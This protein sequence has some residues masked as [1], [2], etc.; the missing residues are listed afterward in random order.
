MEDKEIKILEWYKNGNAEIT[1]YEDG[2]RITDYPDNEP[3]N[4]DYPLSIDLCITNHCTMGCPFCYNNSN[5]NGKHGDIMNLK[6]LDTMPRG[7]EI[8]IGGGSATDHP[9]LMPFLEMLKERGLIANLTVSQWELIN[10]LDLVN[11]MIDKDL[12]HGLGVSYKEP[13]DLIYSNMTGQN[14]VV[15]LI[16]GVHGKEVFD[17]LSKFNVKILI[18]GYKELQRGIYYKDA[19]DGEVEKKIEWLKENLKDYLDKFDVISF[20]NLALKQ[21]DV[22][23]M[24]SEKEW[25]EFYQGNDGQVSCYVDAVNQKVSVSSL[26]VSKSIA[27]EDDMKEMFKK[28]KEIK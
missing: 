17:Y 1:I 6:F 5:A 10:K 4:L 13:Q 22:K 27:L 15:H 2:T 3:L 16:A 19:M 14:M 23:N 24:L 12:I 9:D 20:D 28:I 25:Q 8:A 18:L 21:L 26:N 7:A 11:E